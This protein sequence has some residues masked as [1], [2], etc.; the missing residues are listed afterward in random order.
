MESIYFDIESIFRSTYSE[1]QYALFISKL[2]PSFDTIQ[3]IGTTYV[4]HTPLPHSFFNGAPQPY[5]YSF[6]SNID[7]ATTSPMPK[8]LKM[9]AA[10]DA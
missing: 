1:I 3:F 8:M 6:V 9:T 4:P 2:N 10:R 7:P 5:Q